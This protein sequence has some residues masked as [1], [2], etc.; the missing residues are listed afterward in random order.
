MVSFS[1]L[2][3]RLPATIRRKNGHASNSTQQEVPSPVAA[4]SSLLSSEGTDQPADLSLFW[5]VWKTV[6]ELYVD[7]T[8][9][10]K[11]KMI[12]GAIKGM[13]SSLDDPYTVFMTPDET[14]DFD[15]S[16]NGTLKALA[17]SLPGRT[18]CPRLFLH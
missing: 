6:Y 2:D 15:E 11:Q 1:F 16:L 3:G 12:Y 10:D 7:D 8:A 13:V 17:P 9:L 4:L 18:R 5:K 14:K